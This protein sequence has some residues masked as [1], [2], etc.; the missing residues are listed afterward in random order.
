VGIL[1]LGGDPEA[2]VSD[3]KGTVYINLGDKNAVAV[4]DARVLSVT[5]TLIRSTTRRAPIASITM[6]K[7]S[8]SGSVLLAALSRSRAFFNVVQIGVLKRKLNRLSR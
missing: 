4:I 5:K 3:G 1:D 8:G 7:L 2:A 6:R